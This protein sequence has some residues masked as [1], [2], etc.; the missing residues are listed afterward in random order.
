MNTVFRKTLVFLLVCLGACSGKE[1]LNFCTDP[2]GTDTYTLGPDGWVCF[3]PEIN[4][5][6]IFKSTPSSTIA[7]IGVSG[8]VQGTIIDIGD[9][10]CLGSIANKPTS[11]F[12]TSVEVK[13]KHGYV[14][15]FPD[16]TYGRFFV[17][18]IGKNSA[19]QVTTVNI[20]RQY[21]F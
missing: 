12:A 19:G 21:K 17:A 14:V 6:Y 10:E 16:N 4:G 8:H 2:I 13:V 1:E 20:T 7:S 5:C 18:S 9:V 11:G 3:L 15:K